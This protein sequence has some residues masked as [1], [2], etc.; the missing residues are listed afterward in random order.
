MFVC[1]GV[2]QCELVVSETKQDETKLN[3]KDGGE[4]TNAGRWHRDLWPWDSQGAA[5]GDI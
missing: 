2:T 1:I 4:M 3:A 5:C